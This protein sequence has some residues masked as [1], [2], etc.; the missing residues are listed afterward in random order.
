ME[1]LDSVLS[2]LMTTVVSV[3][4]LGCDAGNSRSDESTGDLDGGPDAGSDADS[5]SDSDTDSD[6]DSDVDTDGDSDGDS[7]SDSDGDTDPDGDAGTD[8][9]CPSEIQVV[10]HDLAPEHPDFGCNMSG[11]G[12]TAGLVLDTLDTNRKP[13]YNPN[14]PATTGGSNPMITS[15]ATFY[16]WF[17]HVPGVNTESTGTLPLIEDPPGSGRFIYENDDHV[18]VPGEGAFT[19][20]IHSEFVYELGQTFSFSG[21][22]DVW[23]FIDN[24]LVVDVGGLHMEESGSVNL[25]TLGLTPGQTYNID[26]FH[27]ERCY[28]VSIFKLETSIDCFEP[29]VVK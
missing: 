11:S 25:D 26:M 9:E 19:T 29:V 24:A 14:P 23:V 20:E 2:V 17:H 7:D 13:Q 27:A 1:K 15:E 8:D 22:D 4:I 12:I 3:L 10:Y 5:D 16:E 28:P 18:V 6:G 21:D